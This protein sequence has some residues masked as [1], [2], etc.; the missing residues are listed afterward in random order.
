M[1]DDLSF[2]VKDHMTMKEFAEYIGVHY[3]T[4]RNMRNRGDVR[5]IKIG[6]HYRIPLEEVNRITRLEDLETK[7]D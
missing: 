1:M 4:V 5:V 7:N 3:E 6:G 2:N